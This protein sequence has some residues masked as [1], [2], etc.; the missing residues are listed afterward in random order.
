MNSSQKKPLKENSGAF[1][2]YEKS[3]LLEVEQA[4]GLHPAGIAQA[5]DIDPR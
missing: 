2:L 3:V 1:F 5:G 4:L